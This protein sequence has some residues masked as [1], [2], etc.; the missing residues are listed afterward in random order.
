MPLELMLPE[1][2]RSISA[3]SVLIKREGN[4][5]SRAPVSTSTSLEPLYA[6][7][8]FRL[9]SE[10]VISLVAPQCD[11]RVAYEILLSHP[12]SFFERA[13]LQDPV[14]MVLASFSL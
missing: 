14:T 1:S 4:A 10:F 9:S 3:S 7:G 11:A 8:I 13:V 5:I 2:W 6:L 12:L